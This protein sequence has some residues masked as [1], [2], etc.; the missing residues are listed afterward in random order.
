MYSE[1][2]KKSEVESFLNKSGGSYDYGD[3]YNDPIT[4]PEII[5]TPDGNYSR[6]EWNILFES[7]R[8]QYEDYGSN[9]T[10]TFTFNQSKDNL[11]QSEIISNGLEAV[12]LVKDSIFNNTAV[13]LQKIQQ[14]N[15][16]QAVSVSSLIANAPGFQED[17]IKALT[18]NQGI[19]NAWGKA[20]VK[21]NAYISGAMALIGVLDGD[22][23]TGDWFQLAGA[24]TGILGTHF[25]ICPPIGLTLSGF[26][27]VLS[28]IGTGMNA[29]NNSNNY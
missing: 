25:F 21:G 15:A 24:A 19:L 13:C 9:Q 2:N 10:D 3:W 4:L 11:S 28:I 20:F 12:A 6:E 26:S 23:T 7:D 29:A 17:L 1:L 27:L 5:V 16:Y 18:N 8:H 22:A 14:T